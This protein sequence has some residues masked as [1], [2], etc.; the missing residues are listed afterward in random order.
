MATFTSLQKAWTLYGDGS[1]FWSSYMRSQFLKS[2]MDG[3]WESGVCDANRIEALANALGTT[4]KE[5]R[6]LEYGCGIGRLV[7]G[8]N[9]LGA[10]SITGADFSL[11][12]IRA[13]MKELPKPELK[14][15]TG[16]M[17]LM[18][19]PDEL[20][21]RFHVDKMGDGYECIVSVMTL[22]H[23][24]PALMQATIRDL[25]SLLT[26]GGWAFLH[27]VH[28]MP[29]YKGPTAPTHEDVADENDTYVEM[30]P[31]N[32]N[33]F[34]T[35]VRESGCVIRGIGT[36][37]SVDEDWVPGVKNALFAVEKLESSSN[38]ISPSP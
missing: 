27:L 13:A 10:A 5:R 22:Y 8:L 2:P 7:R 15:A 16:K 25:L 34:K 37:D 36:H 31:I 33:V 3:F 24:P 26:P 29:C 20:P 28:D 14:T 21:L 38:A 12:H 17:R 19:I 9:I 23:V 6:V 32:I 4:I 11:P 30:H 35:I 1:P 18:Y